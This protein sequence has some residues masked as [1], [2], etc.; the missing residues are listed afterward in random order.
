VLFHRAT[1]FTPRAQIE[2]R[3]ISVIPFEH[4]NDTE[5]I[6]EVVEGPRRAYRDLHEGKIAKE[7]ARLNDPTYERLPI[8]PD[9]VDEPFDLPEK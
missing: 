9:G 7:K 8:R 3:Y 4:A 6:N 1:K 5:Y 2:R